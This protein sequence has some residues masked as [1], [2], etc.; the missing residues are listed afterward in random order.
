MD[1]DKLKLYE[2]ILAHY[3]LSELKDL[4][5]YL[6]VVYDDLDGA[7]RKDKARE[8]VEYMA[9]RGRLD[10]LRAMLSQKRP[11]RYGETFPAPV[12]ET[13]RRN[14][15]TANPTR[16]PRQLFI[17]HATADAAFA[18]RLAADLRALGFPVWIAP[19]SIQP[20]EQWVGVVDLPEY[21]IA[22]TPVTNAQYKRFIDATPNYR[23]PFSESDRDK[24]FCWDRLRR[25]Y[26]VNKSDHPVVLVSYNDAV[27]YCEWAGLVLPT[28][29]QWEKA[30]RGLD[31][32]KWP[33][34]NERPTAEHC[35]FNKNV[36]STSPIDQYSPRGD[37]YYGCS[38]MAGNVW[39]WT[40][41]WYVPD[42]A[43]VVRGGSWKSD[44]LTS[45]VAFRSYNDS[46]I[47]VNHGGFRVVEL[48]SDPGS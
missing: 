43:P 37:S 8:L 23:V 30:A 3:S 39:E 24:P 35:N 17:S 16:N 32:R 2:F 27:A 21:W 25:A 41:S 47:Q 45:R 5:F 12:V 42:K 31:R 33:W 48:L 40:S 13:F 14:V 34:G 38:D 29:E 46:S 18:H 9:R 11:E 44:V 7:A 20:G 4:C 22:C 36:G 10:D 15:S 19:D 6:G 26:P 28:E 1:T